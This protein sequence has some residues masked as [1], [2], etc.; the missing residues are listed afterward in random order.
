MNNS[1]YK[2][3]FY[4]C[5]LFVDDNEKNFCGVF[6]HRTSKVLSISFAI[7][8]SAVNLILLYGII[9]YEHYGTDFKR[10]LTNKLLTSICWTLMYGAFI[11]SW[12]IVRYLFGPLAKL[13]CLFLVIAKN[14]IKTQTVL[15]LD[16]IVITRYVFIFWL[17][18]P[19]RIDDDFWCW[20]LSLWIIGFSHI[21]NFAIYFLPVRQPLY[22]YTCADLDPRADLAHRLKAPAV[23]E[24]FSLILHVV[25]RFKIMLHKCGKT[26]VEPNIG[27]KK[28]TLE[29]LEKK[30][31]GDF[32]SNICGVL[33]LAFVSLFSLKTNSL[34]S[35][36]VNDFPNYLYLY[37]Y[38]L[39]CPY[40]VSYTITFVCYY[41]YQPLRKTVFR[42]AKNLV[43]KENFFHCNE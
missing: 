31:I 23:F 6:E 25:I 7:I 12:D 18:N 27:Y 5:T 16:A 22:Y 29:N 21:V 9:W 8:S 34:I 26:Q 41:R 42:E 37:I 33:G 1:Y 11:C 35:P 15:F 30:S 39:I 4:N 20:F 13:I 14:S 40:L 36:E 24:I 43:I 3:E 28:I 2:N 38:Q 10:T 32:T 19:G 17:K